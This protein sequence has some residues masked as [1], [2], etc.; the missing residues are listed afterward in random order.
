MITTSGVFKKK[1]NVDDYDNISRHLVENE[2]LP[3]IC[4]CFSRKNVERCAQEITTNLLEFDS[5]ISYTIRREAVMLVLLF[6]ESEDE[7]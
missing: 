6:Q 4:Y 2:M 3:A 7:E 5:K 1:R